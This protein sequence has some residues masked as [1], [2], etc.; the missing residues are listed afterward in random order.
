MNINIYGLGYVGS[1]SAACFAAGGHR[2]LGID[3]D[4]LKVDCINRGSSAVVEPGLTELIAAAVSAGTLR[5]TTET[6]EIA[7]VSMICVGTPSNENGSLCLDYVKRAAAQIGESLKTHEPYHVVCVRSTVLPGTVES[8]VIPILEQHSGRTAGQHF[9]VCMNPEFLREGS[10]I[11]DFYAPP[12][13]VIGELDRQSGDVVEGLYAGISAPVIRARL[14][15]AEMVKYVGNAYHGLKVS[16]ANEIGNLCKRFGLDGREVMEIFCRD[17]KLNISAAYLQPGFAFGGSCL[18]KDLR[19]LLHRA[20]EVDL[21]P[22][23]LRSVLAS[24][25]NQIEEAYRLIKHT[26]KRKIAMLGLSFKPGTDDLRESPIAALVEML[27]GKG[28]E[29]TIY[30]REVLLARLHGSNR[31]YIEQTIPHIGRL[32]KPSVE[33]AVEDAELIVVAKRSNEYRESLA[34]LRNGH[35]VIDLASL[36]GAQEGGPNYEGICW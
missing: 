3:I 22:L 12:M 15:V 18:P 16:F 21:E 30:D 10:S 28:H 7:D 26:G 5:A 8:V 33:T 34:R 20:R 1:V 25:T 4:P 14:A 32:M 31:V 29:V 9:G 13:T 36:F 11:A 23:V 24:N 19:A 27:L 35:P 17:E 2:V 6:A